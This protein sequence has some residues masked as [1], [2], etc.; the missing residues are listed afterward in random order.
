MTG[1]IAAAGIASV[2]PRMQGRKDPGKGQSPFD[3][4]M[5]AT[6]PGEQTGRQ[7]RASGAIDIAS[8]AHRK[9]ETKAKTNETP[10]LAEVLQN[11]LRP[12]TA[13]KD[14]DEPNAADDQQS[15]DTDTDDAAADGAGW[16][17]QAR[18]DAA[19]WK[20]LGPD[21][22]SGG[23]MAAAEEP[24]DA[25]RIDTASTTNVATI[26]HKPVGD[27][28]APLA[29]AEATADVPIASRPAAPDAA[30][31]APRTDS[32]P[33]PAAVVGATEAHAAGAAAILSATGSEQRGR[34]TAARDSESAQVKDLRAE[35]AASPSSASAPEKTRVE[36]RARRSADDQLPLRAD[37][38]DTGRSS[39]EQQTPDMPRP[40]V[41]TPAA[42]TQQPQQ[43]LASPSGSV[44]AAL[45]ADPAWSAYFRDTQ[46]GAPAPVR[47]LKIQLNPSELGV[48]TAHLLA[49]DDGL[50]VELV[51]ETVDAQNKLASDSDLIARS[52]RAIGL[53]VDRVTVQL[54]TRNDT[55]TQTDG[56]QPR[57]FAS[58]SGAGGARGDGGQGHNG[59]SGDQSQSMRAGQQANTQTSETNSGRYI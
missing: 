27:R 9:T 1:A 35:P 31:A 28:A 23:K 50:S 34:K 40:S 47:S 10:D 39:P 24:D 15:D 20:A 49:G 46:P 45:S 51:A 4:A 30:R 44:V 58:E 43:Q 55:P 32:A 5:N 38:A 18:F 59:Q 48:V 33:P 42:V 11:A 6:R 37:A 56:G 57:G 19:I 16:M 7:A 53:D 52:L 12:A 17:N 25:P 2:E 54:A 13:G 22:G 8:A 26:A 36:D 3:A 14:I 29:D 21:A 41:A